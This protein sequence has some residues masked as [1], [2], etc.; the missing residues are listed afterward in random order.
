MYGKMHGSGVITWADGK[1]YRGQLRQ[2]QKHGFGRLE[3]SGSVGVTV[4]EGQWRGD[5]MEGKGRI[6]SP[7]GDVYEVKKESNKQ[8]F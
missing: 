7:N 5:K 1:V 3:V 8:L 2:S 6:L 4:Y